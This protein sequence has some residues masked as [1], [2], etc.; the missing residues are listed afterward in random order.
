MVP[1]VEPAEQEGMFRVYAPARS[2]K[3]PR[4]DASVSREGEEED[5][6][7]YTLM[8]GEQMTAY[9]QAFVSE[10]VES[11]ILYTQHLLAGD[12]TV[13]QAWPRGVLTRRR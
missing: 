3:A 7:S 10:Q 13:R 2:T 8:D 9:L 12:V 1:R 11:D 5:A 4:E 6:P